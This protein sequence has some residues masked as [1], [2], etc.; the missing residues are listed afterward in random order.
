MPTISASSSTRKALSDVQAQEFTLLTSTM[1][2]LY[3]GHAGDLQRQQS[4]VNL[5]RGN[6]RMSYSSQEALAEELGLTG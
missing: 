2:T 6:I 4:K 5:Q 3:L 1:G